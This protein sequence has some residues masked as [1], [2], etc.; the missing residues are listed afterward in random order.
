MAECDDREADAPSST[1]IC[2][3]ALCCYASRTNVAFLVEVNESHVTYCQCDR[4]TVCCWVK[5]LKKKTKKTKMKK[6]RR[7]WINRKP[8]WLLL[9]SA[10]SGS[11]ISADDGAEL[12][13][14]IR[15]RSPRCRRASSKQ[16]EGPQCRVSEAA[17]QNA[18][19]GAQLGN[20]LDQRVLWCAHR[21]EEIGCSV[22]KQP[23]VHECRYDGDVHEV[24]CFYS[25]YFRL[26]SSEFETLVIN[27][28]MYKISGASCWDGPS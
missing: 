3:E 17:S 7:I 13:I 18:A 23:W 25:I 26:I 9:S 2:R 14:R 27:R 6:G 16:C 1:E 22:C 12:P 28:S 15:S 11:V 20:V 21:R 8:P 4:L 24:F 19:Y 10:A 5:S